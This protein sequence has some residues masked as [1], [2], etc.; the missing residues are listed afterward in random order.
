MQHSYGGV[1]EVARQWLWYS[2]QQDHDKTLPAQWAQD[3]AKHYVQVLRK[4][5]TVL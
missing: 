4:Y 1:A 5:V 2:S 3:D